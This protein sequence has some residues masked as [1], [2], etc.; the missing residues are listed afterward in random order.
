MVVHHLDPN[1]LSALNRTITHAIAIGG[2]N[3]VTPLGLGV[4]LR[5]YHVL[6]VVS[7]RGQLTV[8]IALVHGVAV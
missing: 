7:F 2:P 1:L 4:L 6:S 3:Q 8:A 5:W